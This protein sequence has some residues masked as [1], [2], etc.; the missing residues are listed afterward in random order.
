[1]AG[2]KR[3]LDIPY[4]G[5]FVSDSPLSW[6][7]RNASKPE[8][9][10][11]ETWVLHANP[12]WSIEHLERER[13]DIVPDLLDAFWT[14]TGVAPVAPAFAVGHRWR[15]ALAE[16]PLDEDCLWDGS[17]RLGVGGDWCAGSRVEGAFLSGAA[18]A[19]RVLGIPDER[20]DEG[21]AVQ[22]SL[23]T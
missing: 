10:D 13:E 4:D 23:F 2:F 18:L 20:S 17:T 11:V 14:A 21:V 3:A 22:T 19:G 5:L 1:M 16:N 6:V 12:D 9:G 8:R 7:A 15:Y